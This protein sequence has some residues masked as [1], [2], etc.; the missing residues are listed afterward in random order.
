MT[1]SS[2]FGTTKSVYFADLKDFDTLVTDEGI[3]DAY[4]SRAEELGIKL[5]V[6]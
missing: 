6:V 2:K 5:L 1:D 4:R 3:P